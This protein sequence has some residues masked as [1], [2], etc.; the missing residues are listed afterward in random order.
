[1]TKKNFSIKDGDLF[2]NGKYVANGFVR[3]Q[4]AYTRPGQMTP[5]S[6]LWNSPNFQLP[7]D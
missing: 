3:I 5:R 4:S 1:M 7:S 2:H 6:G